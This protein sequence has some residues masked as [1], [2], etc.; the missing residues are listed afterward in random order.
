MQ[1]FSESFGQTVGQRL[2]HDGGVVVIGA[3]ETLSDLVFADAGGHSEAADIVGKPA[4]ARRD[5]IAQRGIG[6]ALALGQLLPQRMQHS[7]RLAA[8]LVAEYM[9]IVALG[10][11]RPEP[12]R[13]ARS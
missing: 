6:T 12:E 4:V 1:A 7:D 10:I 2:H 3:L 13:G 11:R 8:I 5:E 9:D